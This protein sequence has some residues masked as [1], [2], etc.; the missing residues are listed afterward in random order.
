[1][2]VSEDAFKE[3]LTVQRLRDLFDNY[4]AD[5]SIAED[6]TADDLKEQDAF[7]DA[8]LDTDVMKM[9]MDFLVE[10]KWVDGNWIR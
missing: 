7:I 1:M 3:S 6:H 4:E 2:N 8:I 5:A 9:L 10:K